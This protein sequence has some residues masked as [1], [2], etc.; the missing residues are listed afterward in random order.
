MSRKPLMQ[1]T[2]HQQ[3]QILWNPAALV[4]TPHVP[5]PGLTLANGGH[6]AVEALA[7]AVQRTRWFS[8]VWRGQ[9]CELPH[10]RPGPR[11]THRPCRPSG[12][13]LPHTL[14]LRTRLLSGAFAPRAGP[15]GRVLARACSSIRAT[16]VISTTASSSAGARRLDGR[17]AVAAHQPEPIDRP[18]RGPGQ[19]DIQQPGGVDKDSAVRPPVRSERNRPH[20]LSRRS[21]QPCRCFQPPGGARGLFF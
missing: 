14:T 7:G 21:Q 1:L 9:G 5:L 3:L 15:P 12:G 11:R 16:L 6:L 19:P 18:H 17:R 4:V 10:R 2:L 13:R 8:D 20:L